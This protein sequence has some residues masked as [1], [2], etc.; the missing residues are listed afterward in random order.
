MGAKRIFTL[1]AM[2]SAI[3]GLAPAFAGTPRPGSLETY[4]D[5]TIGCD[6]RGRCEAVSLMPEGGSWPDDPVTVGIVREPGGSSEPEIW[7]SRDGKGREQL[8]LVI[9]DRKVATAISEEGEA[10]LDGAQAATLAMAIARG[11]RMDVLVGA[12]LVGQPSL[13]GAAAA[14]R[15]MDARQ[16]TAGTR[17]ALVARGPLARSVVRSAPLPIVIRRADIPPGPAP[18]PLWREERAALGRLT[19]CAD[20]MRDASPPEL[21]RLSRTESLVLTPCGAGAYNFTSVPVIASGIAGRRTFRFASFDHPPGWSEAATHPMLVNAAWLA[22][23]ATL[24]S[25]AKG[26]GLGDCGGSESYVWDGT[27]FRLAQASAMG[28]CRGA[29][30]WIKVFTADVVK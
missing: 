23:T 4:K 25:Y 10:K 12:K 8:G 29:R 28:E 22:D 6:N 18:Q 21:H 15:Y 2:L 5:W 30:Q 17:A 1:T 9:D 27:Q 19:G 20:E 16:G 14:L 11:N 13:A 24:E 3:I 7:I 26:R